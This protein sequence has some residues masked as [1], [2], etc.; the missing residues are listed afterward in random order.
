MGNT[1]DGDQM[2]EAT[3][4]HHISPQTWG[5]NML[6]LPTE[7]PQVNTMYNVRLCVFYYTW[8]FLEAGEKR[9]ID[10][11]GGVLNLFEEKK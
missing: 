4:S 3:T 10:I 1:L 7:L 8:R 9:I 6:L 2:H 5:E 11:Y